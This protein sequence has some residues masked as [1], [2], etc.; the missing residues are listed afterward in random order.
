MIDLSRTALVITVLGLGLF[1]GALTFLKRTQRFDSFRS[2]S[3]QGRLWRRRFATASKDDLRAFLQVFV[4]AFAI[5]PRLRLHF[6]PD[7]RVLDIYRAL[8]P[9]D[10][11]RA[12]A[13]ELELYELNFHKAYGIRLGTVWHEKMTLGELFQLTLAKPMGA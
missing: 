10:W 12:D 7:D 13:M 3:C 1:A 4:K 9:P 2:R 11:S 6:H 5:N 8:N